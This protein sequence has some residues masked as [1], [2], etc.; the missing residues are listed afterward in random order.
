[1]SGGKSRKRRTSVRK[2]SGPSIRFAPFPTMH[3]LR[4]NVFKRGFQLETL[5]SAIEHRIRTS[6]RFIVP[7][8]QSVLGPGT[9]SSLSF[10]LLHED[11]RRLIF[12]LRALNT[13]GKRGRF[14][15]VVAK[16]PVAF[17]EI[18]EGEHRNLALLSALA[19][20]KMLQVYRGGKVFL[21]DRHR[22]ADMGR[23]L[24]AFVAQ[25]VANS[26]PLAVGRNGQFMTLE[27]KR[28]TYTRK[29]T[30]Q[31]KLL[32]IDGVLRSYDSKKCECIAIADLNVE[33]IFTQTTRHGKLRIRIIS[34]PKVLSRIDPTRVIKLILGTTWKA[35][36]SSIS[37][38]PEDP[39]ALFA[40]FVAVLGR[41]MTADC[42]TS[43]MGGARGQRIR[44][45]SGAYLEALAESTRILG[46]R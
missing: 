36:D 9:L 25:P 33:D 12:D 21:P 32:I 37:L 19:P 20:D 34:C 35:G 22:R 24:Y 6:D 11:R 2:H 30:E 23:E 43:L 17:S 18:L 42:F 28:H 27:P 39:R 8:I 5:G 13:R 7:S 15:L 45:V 44:G 38:A 4:G 29:A 40:Q 16:N 14:S 1:M 31:L 41:D 10:E 3:D 26:Y 46:K